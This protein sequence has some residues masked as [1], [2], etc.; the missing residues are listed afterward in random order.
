[1]KGWMDE[2]TNDQIAI[3]YIFSSHGFYQGCGFRTLSSLPKLLL[4]KQIARV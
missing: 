4:Q 2:S 1:M 3:K